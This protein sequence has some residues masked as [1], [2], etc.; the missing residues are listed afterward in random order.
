MRVVGLAVAAIGIVACTDARQA[1]PEAHSRAAV[2][3]PS[4]AP[5]RTAP[6][7][8]SDS[9]FVVAELS[10]TLDSAGVVKRLGQPDSVRAEGDPFGEGGHSVVFFYPDL[11]TS[12][13]GGGT[14]SMVT[15]TTPR[16]ATRRGL[17]VGDSPEKALALYGSVRDSIMGDWTFAD[18]DPKKGDGHVIQ[19]SFSEGRVKSIYVGWVID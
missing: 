2:A 4:P 16:F 10:E 14:L 15:L 3:A 1:T 5:A 19:L 12:V 17:R 6:A 18:P 13:A 8:L 7:P 11:L 9:D